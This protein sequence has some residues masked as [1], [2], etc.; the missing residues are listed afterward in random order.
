M[1][2]KLALAALI[3]ITA[4]GQAVAQDTPSPIEIRQTAFDLMAGDFGGINAVVAAKG[5]TKPLE[6]RAKAIAR[7]AALIPALFPPGSNV[8]G[9]T[10]AL[11]EVWSDRAGFEKAA[12]NLGAAATKLAESAKGGDLELIAADVKGVSGACGACHKEYRAK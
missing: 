11:P 6:A 3:V 9:N 7:Y 4:T 2:N 5:D 1:K 12:A 10:K 8:G